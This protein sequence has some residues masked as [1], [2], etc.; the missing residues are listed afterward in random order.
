MQFET[1]MLAEV[2]IILDLTIKPFLAFALEYLS[3]SSLCHAFTVPAGTI[4]SNFFKPVIMLSGKHWYNVEHR[5]M[6][7]V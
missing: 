6:S 7:Y 4:R 2:L 3:E 1:C 5:L